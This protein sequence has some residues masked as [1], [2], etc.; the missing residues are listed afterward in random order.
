MERQPA[1]FGGEDHLEH[2]GE[3]GLDNTLSGRSHVS[4]AAVVH[5]T[6]SFAVG[7]FAL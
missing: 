7:E 4:C 6:Q 2:S 5:S 1:A 3:T